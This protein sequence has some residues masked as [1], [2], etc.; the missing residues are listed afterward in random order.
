MASS[1]S[2]RMRARYRSGI[3]YR[4]LMEECADFVRFVAENILGRN[5]LSGKKGEIQLFQ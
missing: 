5:T 3:S 1:S 4:E 2:C